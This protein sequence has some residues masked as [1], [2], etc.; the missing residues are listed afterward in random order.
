MNTKQYLKAG[1]KV[2]GEIKKLASEYYN[3]T[4]RPLGIT[5][6]I[7][8]YEAVRILKLDVSDVRQSG[9]DATRKVNNI[10]RK[11]QIKG[12]V[13]HANSKTGQ[14]VGSIKLDKEWDLVVL[15]LMDSNF[16]ATEIYEAVRKDIKK[17]LTEGNSKARN[18][19]GSLGVNKFKSIA[20]LVWKKK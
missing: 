15:V 7:A 4:G 20:S 5:G 2:L 19:R 11:I 16:N 1:G 12:R 14:R 10:I 18:E 13:I 9:F 8:E 3:L 17:A 6:E